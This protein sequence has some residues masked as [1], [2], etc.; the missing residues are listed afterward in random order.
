MYLIK[1]IIPEVLK[2]S[3]KDPEV[4]RPRLLQ[5]GVA[6]KVHSLPVCPGPPRVLL[7]GLSTGLSVMGP[8]PIYKRTQHKI[9]ANHMLLKL[10]GWLT[11]QP[12][13]PFP[14]PYFT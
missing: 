6:A 1:N 12:R 3:S 4:L 2:L 5:A 8:D 14:F 10:F 9:S 7:F 13:L 11:G